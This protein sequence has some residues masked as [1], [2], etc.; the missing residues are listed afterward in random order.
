LET[1]AREPPDFVHHFIQLSQDFRFRVGWEWS[2]ADEWLP[3]NPFHPSHNIYPVI[4][5]MPS[6]RE[7]MCVWLQIAVL[8]LRKVVWPYLSLTHSL[9][10]IKRF[11]VGDVE[12]PASRWLHH[13]TCFLQAYTRSQCPKSQKTWIWTFEVRYIVSLA[14]FGLLACDG[15]CPKFSILISTN[16]VVSL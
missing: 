14:Q 12:P 7:R 1:P 3:F 8:R 4:I 10:R 6:V 2:Y 9:S 5:R 16:L 11:L 13:I 15:G